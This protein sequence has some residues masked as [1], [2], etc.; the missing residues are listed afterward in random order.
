MK[1]DELGLPSE[2][3]EAVA[4][5]VLAYETWHGRPGNLPA[6]TG[7]RR[8]VILG[9]LTPKSPALVKSS[10]RARSSPLLT[11]ARNPRT[12]RIDE[13]PT[14]E[15][16]RL[17]NEED[18]RVAVAVAAELPRLAEA[19][20]RIAEQMRAGGRLIYVGAGTSGRL[21]VLDAAECLPTFGISP[22]QVLALIAGGPRAITE[23]VEGAEDDTQSGER[24]VAAL[25]VNEHDSVV[26][27]AASGRTPYVLG[28]LREAG[29][30][31]A[32]TISL[33]NNRPSPME[34]L[35]D[36]ALAPL[37]GPEVVTGSTRL[38]A[39]TAQKLTLN[40]L[41]T[42]VMIRLGKT[43]GNLMVDVQPTNA[44]LRERARQIVQ[45]TCRL[46]PE[47]AAAILE[48]C[49]GEAKT[50][51][52]AIRTGRSPAEARRRL[53]EVGGMIRKALEE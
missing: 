20:D 18:A 40:T 2:A 3:K 23:S 26:G 17:I 33:A 31:G 9:T 14:L 12:E 21:G 1:I 22:G 25:Q 44:K 41:S 37:A 49:D 43:F 35:S 45:D 15:M 29:K 24:D 11:E 5:A 28:A 4:F 7:A 34:S 27:I 32:L 8:P 39:G 48:A 19:I 16:V 53:M 50:A 52:V 30:R 47:Q 38:K 10:T 6:A 46:S 42:G 51:I 36:I 13:L